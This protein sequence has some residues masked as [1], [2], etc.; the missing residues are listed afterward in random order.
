MRRTS[1]SGRAS[2][3]RLTT[4]DK[5]FSHSNGNDQQHAEL[6]DATEIREVLAGVLG[7]VTQ[8]SR[9]R[10]EGTV[11]GTIRIAMTAFGSTETAR[12]SG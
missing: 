6:A 5:N 9:K 2:V 4:D 7:L 1:V 10:N 8:T 11:Y 3:I 12:L